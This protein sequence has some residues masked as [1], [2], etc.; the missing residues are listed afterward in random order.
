MKAVFSWVSL[1]IGILPGLTVILIGLGTPA[2][3]R[4]PFGI[5]A[6]AWGLVAFTVVFL[7]NGTAVRPSKKALIGLTVVSGIVGCV[8]LS[9][10]W[11]V[12]DRCV[13]YSDKRSPAFFPLWLD[14]QAREDVESVGG[15]QA[16]YERYGVGAVSKLVE[17]QSSQMDRTKLLLVSLISAGSFAMGV[18]SGLVLR[19]MPV[20]RAPSGKNRAGV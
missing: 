12:L 15:R 19:K 20:K 10:Y 2:D 1:V 5:I 3:L 16:Y 4:Q 11:I 18:W 9:S 6:A 7:I 14:G 13:F 17:T 8:L